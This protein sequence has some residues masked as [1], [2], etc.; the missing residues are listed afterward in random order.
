MRPRVLARTALM[1][2]TLV[3][4]AILVKIAMFQLILGY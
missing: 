4:T 1:I 3:L 2:V